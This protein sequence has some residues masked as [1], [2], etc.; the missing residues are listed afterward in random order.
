MFSERHVINRWHR[1]TMR[2]NGAFSGRKCGYKS[3][4]TAPQGGV[5]VRFWAMKGVGGGA[6]SWN[7][8]GK[9]RKNGRLGECFL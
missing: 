2:D 3:E 4:Q 7:N 9:G 5:K 8:G 6:G 1:T